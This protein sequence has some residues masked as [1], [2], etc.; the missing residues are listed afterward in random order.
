VPKRLVRPAR[1]RSAPVWPAELVEMVIT[2]DFGG[3]LP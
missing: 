3:Q 1:C 2:L